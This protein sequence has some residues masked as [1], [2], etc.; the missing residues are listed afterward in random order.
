MQT[1]IRRLTKLEYQ[2]GTG[3][4]KPRLLLV[5]CKAGWGLAL[6]VDACIQILDEC[7]SLPTGPVG[8]VNLL[9]IPEGLNPEQTESFLQENG[10]RTLT[11]SVRL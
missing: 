5:L 3:N 9:S 4:R 11:S 8:L 1:V 2:F 10:P 7:G 6:D